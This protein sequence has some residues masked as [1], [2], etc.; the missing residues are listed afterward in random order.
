MGSIEELQT[1]GWRISPDGYNIVTENGT[2]RDKKTIVANT[3]NTDI[4]EFGDPL[5]TSELKQ[6]KTGK[7]ILQIQKIRNIAAPK[8]KEES[9][10]APRMLKLTLTD[11]HTSCQA[12]EIGSVPSLSRTH[13][14]PG[15]K[16]LVDSAVVFSSC[17]LLHSN[18]CRL[19]GG[20]VPALFEKWEL[21]KNISEHVRVSAGPDGP[22]PWV[23]FGE[24]I[25]SAVTGEPF[26]ALVTKVTKET[27]NEFDAH[28]QDA[29]AVASTGAVKK[30]FGGG[31]RALEDQPANDFR[32]Y[33]SR[34]ADNQEERPRGF[35]G[36]RDAKE[37]AVDKPQKP[38][39][40]ISLFDFL[41]DK[42]LVNESD[43]KPNYK[44]AD[45][46][47]FSRYEP[48][49]QQQ[50]WEGPRNFS[51]LNSPR[52][53]QQRYQR[54]PNFA[55]SNA[56]AVTYRNDA[57]NPVESVARNM[58]RMSLNSQF[59][60]RSLQQHLNLGNNRSE[61]K[62][63]VDP[64]SGSWHWNVGDLCMAKYWEDGKY[65][66]ATVTNLT[67][68]TCVVR[69]NGYGNVEEVLKLDC[70]PLS[71]EPG[72][73]SQFSNPNANQNY[74]GSAGFRNSRRVYSNNR[75]YNKAT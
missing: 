59:A 11:G 33:G 25:V 61:Y 75:P 13:T 14:P 22:P 62:S 31:P 57:V 43:P 35:K 56:D 6:S 23:N 4:K 30:V 63:K 74:K 39:E 69:F 48:Q 8:S 65:Y 70:I 17:I 41:E 16:L 34:N 21:A 73:E 18:C 50:R 2:V 54:A 1:D 68:R 5:L 64:G 46:N 15:S 29:I 72:E 37:K 28:R 20:R 42:L 32:R 47:N 60:T 53:Q 40:R 27:S 44:A 49:R 38:P 71:E 67:E 55:R 26:K 52:F 9:Q 36:R 10:A 58:G 19:L 7:V 24:K 12:V 3:L 45:D 66:N 51:G